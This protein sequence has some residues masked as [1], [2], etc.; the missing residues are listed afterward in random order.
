MEK[1]TTCTMRDVVQSNRVEFKKSQLMYLKIKR[2]LDITCSAMGVLVLSPVFLGAAIAVKLE[3]PTGKVIYKQDRIGRSGRPFKL[4]KFRTMHT[5]APELSTHE[6]NNAQ[7]Y[8]TRV[9]RFMRDTSL[10]ELPQLINVLKGDMSLVGPRPLMTRERDIHMKRF[11]YGL[12]Q[13]RPGITGMAQT[14]G[15][16]DMDNDQ[17]VEWDRK[18]VEKIS[19]MTDLKLIFRTVGKVIKREGVVDKAKEDTPS[20]ENNTGKYIQ[21]AEHFDLSK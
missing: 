1:E 8:V 5:D 7:S 11:F 18:Y 16:D 10:D 15:R 9:G 17:K 13:V 12:Y 3:D 21:S 19:F 6:F 20:L 4:Y 14:H 2:V